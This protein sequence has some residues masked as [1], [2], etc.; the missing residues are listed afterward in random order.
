MFV[1]MI[2]TS[3]SEISTDIFTVADVFC[4]VKKALYLPKYCTSMQIT[5]RIREEIVFLTEF[6]NGFFAAGELCAV[7]IVDQENSTCRQTFIKQRKR[8][9][10]VCIQRYETESH[11]CDIGKSIRKPSFMDHS[12]CRIWHNMKNRVNICGG[13]ISSSGTGQ[14][15]GGL[16]CHIFLRKSLKRIKKMNPAIREGCTDQGRKLALK[17]AQFSNIARNIQ[18]IDLF[19]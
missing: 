2:S 9:G 15:A 6:I 7:H 11:I 8:S 10:E 16:N 14:I 5:Y 1:S 19:C 4:T 12:T 13:E 17:N 18:L 3:D